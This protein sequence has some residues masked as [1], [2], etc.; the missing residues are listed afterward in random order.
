MLSLRRRRG[1]E[2][3]QVLADCTRHPHR[4]IRAN[5]FFSLIERPHPRDTGELDHHRPMWR[6]SRIS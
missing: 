2:T 3:I 1:H 4:E 5:L 6:T